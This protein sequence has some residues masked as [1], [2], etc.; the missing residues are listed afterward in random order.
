MELQI[1]ETVITG[2]RKQAWMQ[3]AVTYGVVTT[4]EAEVL[5]LFSTQGVIY[6]G[7]VQGAEDFRPEDCMHLQR[8][9]TRARRILEAYMQPLPDYL[10]PLHL[11]GT[12]WM[13]AVWRTLA[14]VACGVPISYADL[15]ARMGKRRAVRAVA[16]AVAQNPISIV[17]PC[18]RIIRSSGDTGQY[19]WGATLKK[20]MLASEARLR[21]ALHI[22]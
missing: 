2:N 19:H 5:V 20:N 9:D 18:H 11:I 17:I 21:P 15:A 14:S 1:I 3:H 12:E 4:S 16:H 10:E 13:I 8:N 7:M 6:I 22:L